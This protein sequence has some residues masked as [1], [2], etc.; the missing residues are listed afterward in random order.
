MQNIFRWK[1][2][3]GKWFF[4]VCVC[5]C[6]FGCI[7]KNVPENIL[8]FCIKDI[9]EGARGEVYVFGKWFTKKLGVNHFPNFNK[10][11]SGQRKSFSIWPPFYSETNTRKSENIFRKIFYNETNGAL[12]AKIFQVLVPKIMKGYLNLKEFLIFKS[13]RTLKRR[14]CFKEI[15]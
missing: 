9:A 6:V 3:P 5:V 2:F 10:G 7:P 8:Q 14:V 4:F 1:W 11:F 12:S 15:F 13:L